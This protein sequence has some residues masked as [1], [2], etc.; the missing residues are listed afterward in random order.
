MTKYSDTVLY[1]VGNRPGETG[2]EFSRFWEEALSRLLSFYTE[3]YTVRK[4]CV[5]VI[6]NECFGLL[7]TPVYSIHNSKL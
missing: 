5:F 7:S 6:M 4:C 2:R 1:T 3:S